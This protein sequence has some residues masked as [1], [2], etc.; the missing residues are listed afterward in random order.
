MM[1]IEKCF[2][3]DSRQEDPKYRYLDHIM[4]NT[5]ENGSEFVL[6]IRRTERIMGLG[7]AATSLGG[8]FFRGIVSGYALKKVAKIIAIMLGLFLAGLACL[9]RLQMIT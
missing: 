1:H 4:R 6:G 2:N 7:I 9:N 3:H 5:D 8:G